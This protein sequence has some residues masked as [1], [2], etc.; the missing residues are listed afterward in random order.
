MFTAFCFILT[1]KE[2]AVA[3]GGLWSK[4]EQLEARGRST[5]VLGEGVYFEE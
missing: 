3:D 1:E 4:G 5:C 2:L